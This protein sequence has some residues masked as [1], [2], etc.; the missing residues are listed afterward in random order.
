[1]CVSVGVKIAMIEQMGKRAREVNLYMFFVLFLQL[2]SK[3]CDDL[4]RTHLSKLAVRNHP[5]EHERGGGP[6]AHT[7][8]PKGSGAELNLK[9]LALDLQ[10]GL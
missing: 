3:F 9:L 1:M 6:A 5:W 8:P 2:F 4:Q 7:E 10:E